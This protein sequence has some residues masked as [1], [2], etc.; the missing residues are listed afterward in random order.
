MSSY[1]WARRVGPYRRIGSG[2]WTRGATARGLREKPNSQGNRGGSPLR[3]R[4]FLRRIALAGTG[5]I[6]RHAGLRLQQAQPTA[7]PRTEITPIRGLIEREGKLFQ[8]VQISLPANYEVPA[9]SETAAIRIGDVSNFEA[10][11]PGTRM[12]EALV[13]A[14]EKER[15]AD[16]SAEIAGSAVVSGSVTLKPVRKVLIYVLPHSHNDIGYT[17]LQAN[18]ETKQMR[19]VQIGIDLARGTEAYPEGSRFVWNMEGCWAAD[20]WMRRTSESSQAEFVDAVR[21]GWVALNGMYANELTGLCRPEE[22]LEAFRC[23][24]QLGERCGVKVDSAMISDVPGFTWG[25]VTA[26][27]QAGIRYFSAAPNWF[28]RIGTLMQVWQD[29]PFWLISPSGRERVLVWVP[30]TGYAMSHVFEKITPDWVGKYQDR[31][32]QVN[33]PYDISY[34]RWSGHGDNAEPD[35]AVCEDIRAW[36]SKYAWPK[37]Y[38]SSTSRAFSAFEGRHGK[39]VPE[40]RGDLTPY[41]E[42]GAGSSALETAMNRDT[43]D[44]LVQAA[45]LLAMA[46]A[47]FP[48]AAFENAWRN[49]LL[50]SEHTWGAWNSVSDSENQFV[51][52]QWETKR[53]FAIEAARQSRDLLDR[54]LGRV[55]GRARPTSADA[56]EV[57]NTSSWPRTELVTLGLSGDRN[58]LTRE[59]GERVPSQRLS[60]GELAMWAMEVPPFCSARYNISAGGAYKPSRP[61]TIDG[62]TLDNGLVRVRVDPKTGGISELFHYASRRNLADNSSTEQINEYLFLAGNNLANLQSNGPATLAIEEPGPLVATMRIDSDAPGC[63]RLVRKIRLVAGTEYVELLNAIDKKRAPMNPHSGEGGPGG[64]WAQHGGKESVQFAFPFNVT[65]SRIRIDVPLAVMRPETDQLPGACKNWMPV[66]RWVDVANEEHGVTWASLDAPLVEI[67]EISADLLGSERDPNVWR[68]DIEPTQKFYSWVMNNH[69]GTNY[70]PYQEG[71]V[72]FRYALRPHEGYDPAA[73]ARFATGL[74]QPLIAAPAARSASPRSPLLRVEPDDVLVT[75]LKPSDDGQAWIVR[76][77][78]ASGHDRETKLVWA[79]P[80]PSKVW[81]SDLAESRI[82]LASDPL[83]VGAW[84][85]V[86][87]RADRP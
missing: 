56:V 44:R 6:S 25:T 59:D 43:A 45:A 60:T 50:Y 3:R 15:V 66:G 51:K 77:F 78:G 18:V 36:N 10:L 76:L 7:H 29:K 16:V 31:L 63:N 48:A 70:R 23:G 55:A 38:I 52:E 67:G 46:S 54:S 30:W 87:L 42:D 4:E 40:F 68:K 2:D 72:T 12:I 41:W 81:I 37:F 8:P 27:S 62:N 80:Q 49:V 53:S 57:Y 71:V 65:Q 79:S 74:G 13:P 19:N 28:D 17:D 9:H 1:R 32:D 75:T 83:A 61:V 20:M 11:A 34:I 14:V 73:A 39:Q 69:W 58:R 86:T 26:M 47:D 82:S 22:L 64:D 5:L 33:F 85:L 35:R 84:D 21:K 24:I